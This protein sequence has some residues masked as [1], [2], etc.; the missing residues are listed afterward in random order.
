MTRDDLLKLLDKN[1]VGAELGVCDGEFSEKILSTVDPVRL[2]LIDVWRY[3]D[4]G[5][6]DGLMVNDNKQ[7]ARYRRVV[8]KFLN[9]DRVRVIRD[10]TAALSEILPPKSLDWIYIDADH[11][12]RGCWKDLEIAKELV[13]DGGYI[14]GH[15]YN[16]AENYGVIEAVDRFVIEQRCVLSVI[17]DERAKSYCISTTESA[18]QSLQ[19]RIQKWTANNNAS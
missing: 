15:D 5:Y 18:H 11:S 9:D 2:Y 19:Q 1:T 10:Y 16:R 6:P 3:I 4:L 8:G 12:F 17:T 13:R 14:M 7:A